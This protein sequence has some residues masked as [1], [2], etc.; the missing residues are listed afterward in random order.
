MTAYSNVSVRIPAHETPHGTDPANAGEFYAALGML[1]VAWGRLEGHITG[2]L[3]TIMNLLGTAPQEPLPF[4]WDKRLTLWRKGF[5]SM[6]S[7]E[8]H[9]ERAIVLMKSIMDAA[10]DRNFAAHAVWDEFVS[11][12]GEPTMTAR[13]L[14]AKKGCRNIIEV[15][16]RRITLSMVN[17]ALVECNRLNLEMTEFTKL[18]SL[19]KP[20][21]ADALR[22]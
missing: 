2:N 7:L 11:D 15:D 8:I 16:D 4:R 22:L 17:R 3:L 18:L 5:S 10:N 20:P 12:A 6:P 13:S 21:P 1:S 9:K 19:I 14:K